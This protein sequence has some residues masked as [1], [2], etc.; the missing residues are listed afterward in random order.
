M[1]FL[2]SFLSLKALGVKEELSSENLEQYITQI[3]DYDSI[4][5]EYKPY[6]LKAYVSGII[7]GYTDGTFKA[8]KATRDR[9]RK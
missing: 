9:D 3:A 1:P 2:R 5:E 4:Y 8:S 6:I 7:G